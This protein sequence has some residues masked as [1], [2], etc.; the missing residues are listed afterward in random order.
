MTSLRPGKWLIVL[1]VAVPLTAGQGGFVS[2][3]VR[4]SSGDFAA[5]AEVRIQSEDTGAQQKVYCNVAGFYSSTELGTGSYK[6]IVRHPGFRTYT[7]TDISVVAGKQIRID[8][9]IDL[10]PL[11]QEMTVRASQTDDDPMRS[12]ITV[13]RD[14]TA[15]A[16]LPLTSLPLNG[17]DVHALLPLM[18]GVIITPASIT[19]G[20]QFTVGGQ[21]P[22]SNSFRVD[23]VS[24]N[25]GIGIISIPGDFP[26]GSLPGMTTIGSMQSLASDDETQRVELRSADFSAQYGDRPGAQV[27][28]E[29][30]SG[31]NDFH[32]SAFG[33]IRPQG[34]SSTDWFARGAAVDLRRAFLDGW[35]G[36]LGGP[37]WRNHTY[38]FGSFEREDVHDSALEVIAVPSAAA[39]AELGT[40]YQLLAESF[41]APTE[42]AL[43]ADESAGQLPFKKAAALTDQSVRLDQSIGKHVQLFSRFSSVPSSSTSI[44][45]GTAYSAFKWQ[46]ATAGLTIVSGDLVQDVRF[47]WTQAGAVAEH[48]PYDTPALN[49]LNQ[50][51]RSALLDVPFFE[52][53]QVSIAGVGQ[54]VAGSLGQSS[55]IQ[56]TATYDLA[57]AVGR[58]NW[59]FGGDY[60]ALIPRPAV[61]D[62]AIAITSPGI[63]A[64]LEGVPLGLTDSAIGGPSKTRQGSL[65]AQDTV[66]L[67]KRLDFLLGLRWEITPPD[68]DTRIFDNNYPYIG[69]WRGIGTDPV[70]IADLNS[71]T[72]SRW[73]MRWGQIA[74]RF[75]IAYRLRSPDL[76]FRAGVGLFYDTQM[77]SIIDNENPLSAWQYLPTTPNP[78]SPA[79]ITASPQPT[80]Y[81]PRVWEWR[82][83]LE[84]EIHDASQLSVSYFGSS[85]RKLLRNEATEDPATGVLQ[86]LA[87]TSH[88]IC[89][90]EAFLAQYRGNLTPQLFILTS[91]TWSHSIDNGSSDT[92]PELV[93]AG[94]NATSDIGSSSFDIRHLLTAS[95][96]YKVPSE[97]FSPRLQKFLGGWHFSSTLVARTGFPFDVT[98]IDRSVGLG[99]DDTGRA[100]LVPG[101]PIWIANSGIPGGRQLNPAAFTAPATGLNGTL[102]RNDLTG[103]GLF[104]IDASLR[105]Q[106][107]LF[108]GLSMETSI[109]AFNTLNHPAFANP[110]NYLGNALFGRSTSMTNLML[111]SGSPTTG[112][113][114]LFQSGGPRTIELGLRF[115][116]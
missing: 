25:V 108:E 52:V 99:F 82:T 69:Y 72:G 22:N 15:A 94:I 105:R 73:P 85:G 12:G 100:S 54:S 30:R 80:L 91:Y 95:V 36:T 63:N 29:T 62:N 111:G 51:M 96:G 92:T 110:V 107:R 28:I 46:T 112:L 74:P 4:D 113:T 83:S 101:E 38:F 3:V 17:H 10:L 70:S 56:E 75:G 39:R 116:F 40:P 26:G 50:V 13:S 27:D 49:Q 23:G 20:G 64:L 14:S 81:L 60:L 87:F 77:G 86:N 37:I 43:T 53:T 114:P 103:N 97:T 33:Y 90:Y 7:R 89:N 79:N 66:H 41:P 78:Q 19:A 55:E 18:P 6:L 93:G 115:T 24:G 88:G 76:V 35:S 98:T 21:R 34:L 59:R 44:E 9:T 1:V 84:K 2:G 8:L 47:N 42:N 58:Q 67:N 5:G 31:T 16:S 32:G 109:S 106:F 11:Q 45:L 61:D 104:Q 65:F 71:L 48:G 102:G 57:R 68:V